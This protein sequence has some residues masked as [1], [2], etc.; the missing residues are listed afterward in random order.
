MPG[1]FPFTNR[2]SPKLGVRDMAG[3]NDIVFKKLHA[4]GLSKVASHNLSEIKQSSYIVIY[5]LVILLYIF[6]RLRHR[7]WAPLVSYTRAQK[8][9]LVR[10]MQLE[11]PCLAAVLPG[12]SCTYTVLILYL[13]CTGA[14]DRAGAGDAAGGALPGGGAAGAAAQ[15]HRAGQ[16]HSRRLR[17]RSGDG[18]RAAPHRDFQ[19]RHSAG[20]GG[21]ADGPL[22]GEGGRVGAQPQ[23][24]SEPGGGSG[25]GAEGKGKGKGGKGSGFEKTKCF[26]MN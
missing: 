12:L 14:E 2:P 8:I 15:R 20:R 3:G 22:G 6:A 23:F 7:L 5:I 4:K 10:K 1:H 17:P 9:E 16:L 18:P 13:Y 24:A 19:R 26:K 25:Q 11:A 21:E